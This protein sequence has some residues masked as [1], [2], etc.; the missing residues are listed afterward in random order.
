MQLTRMGGKKA[1]HIIIKGSWAGR[2]HLKHID[3]KS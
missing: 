1:L 3:T 2:Y